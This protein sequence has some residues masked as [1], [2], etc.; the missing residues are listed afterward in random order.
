MTE[1]ILSIGGNI[2][3]REFFIVEAMRRLI[4]SPHIFDLE[5]S[6]LYETDPVGYTDQAAFLN[7]CVKI[8]TDFGPYELLDYVNSIEND[9]GRVRTIRWGPRTVDIDIIL[10]GDEII[11]TEKLTV[12]HPRFKERSFVTVP[13]EDLGIIVPDR[14]EDP[15]Q[16]IRK[17]EWTYEI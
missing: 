14:T 7:A 12:P 4:K 5:R 9:L 8:R 16:G 6:S 3:D 1:A 10:Y 13:M 17:L 15:T 2:G 11:D